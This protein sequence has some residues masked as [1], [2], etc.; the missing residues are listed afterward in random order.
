[1]KEIN[2]QHLQLNNESN[3]NNKIEERNSN[4][5]FHEDNLN[6]YL[7]IPNRNTYN[8]KNEE[9][10][11]KKIKQN[12]EEEDLNSEID[13]NIFEPNFIQINTIQDIMN[14]ENPFYRISTKNEIA[15]R[16]N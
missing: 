9:S 7:L 14:L 12:L 13:E 16:N 1:M 15:L 5:L 8:T 2:F 10:E 11:I 3:N 6:E 4:N